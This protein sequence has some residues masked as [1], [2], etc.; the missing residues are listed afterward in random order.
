[1]IK[2]E[3]RKLLLVEYERVSNV[4]I[5]VNRANMENRENDIIK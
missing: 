2:Y 1:M 5:Y 3:K 4:D